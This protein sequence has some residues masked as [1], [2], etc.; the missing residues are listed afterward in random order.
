MQFLSSG[1]RLLIDAMDL[2][3]LHIFLQID[4]ANAQRLRFEPHQTLDH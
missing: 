2:D 3:Y 4:L 1:L